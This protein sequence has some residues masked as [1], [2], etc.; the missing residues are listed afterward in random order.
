MT[1]TIYIVTYKRDL[2]WFKWCLASIERFWAQDSRILI[3]CE[4]DDVPVVNQMAAEVAPSRKVETTP[5]VQWGNG[6]GY[7][8]QQW[9]KLTAD[10]LTDSDII[11]YLDSDVVLNRSI[12][13]QD[14]MDEERK[15]IRWFCEPYT[16]IAF[17]EPAAK[18]WLNATWR[19]FNVRPDY[20][21]MR[22][23]P[24]ILW[25]ET[26]AGCRRYLEGQHGPLANYL[27]NMPGGG[28]AFEFSEFNCLGFYAWLFEN[29]RYWFIDVSRPEQHGS[30]IGTVVKDNPI[31]QHHSWTGDPEQAHARFL[32]SCEAADYILALRQKAVGD[33]HPSPHTVGTS[34]GQPVENILCPD[35]P[36]H[37]PSPLPAGQPD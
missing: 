3:N 1:S 12:G 16:S 33:Q 19:A 20:E 10:E 30:T 36:E 8:F 9:A 25:R 4:P 2:P 18:C 14:F 21:F 32:Q 22:R 23:H 5:W 6:K 17:S 11:I 15:R 13:I 35:E 31:D 37:D 28:S 26:L 29:E 24:F 27:L 34:A 7:M